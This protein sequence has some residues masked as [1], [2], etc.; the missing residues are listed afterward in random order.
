MM[1]NIFARAGSLCLIVLLGMLCR[2]SPVQANPSELKAGIDSCFAAGDYERVELLVLRLGSARD[3]LTDKEYS[4]IQL[5]AGFAMIMLD[6][7]ADARR[8]FLNALETD[9]GLTLDPVQVSPKFRVVF[10]DVKTEFRLTE[11]DKPQELYRGP[12]PESYLMNLVLPGSGQI[13]EGRKTRGM[14]IMCCQAAAAGFLIYQMQELRDSRESY[15]SVTDSDL[16]PSAYDRY[17]ED[18]RLTW[19]YVALTGAVYL[20]SQADLAFTRTK[21][22]P[23][24]SGTRLSIQSK[25]SSLLFS[26]S[27]RW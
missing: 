26:L 13:R 24:E 15:L 18:Y 2:T 27:V 10:E 21:I 16:I 14:V 12:L 7:K 23:N 1:N 25:R 4:D 6:R 8:Y 17:N 3:G 11:R 19:V 9:P 20:A 5:T 22:K